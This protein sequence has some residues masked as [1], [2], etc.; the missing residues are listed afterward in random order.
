MKIG[1]I[2]IL[3]FLL[4]LSLANDEFQSLGEMW[5]SA[6]DKVEDF[7]KDSSAYKKA[8]EMYSV[9]KEKIVDTKKTVESFLDKKGDQVKRVYN[10]TKGKI[11]KNINQPI[12]KTI[13]DA[14]KKLDQNHNLQ[15]SLRT[16]KK[17]GLAQTKKFTEKSLKGDLNKFKDTAENLDTPKYFGKDYTGFSKENYKNAWNYLKNKGI[18]FSDRVK[19]MKKRSISQNLG[20]TYIRSELQKNQKRMLD[21]ETIIDGT[22]N[23]EGR[24]LET[25]TVV[26]FE[27]P[28]AFTL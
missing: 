15:E 6:K 9:P 17:N 25:E 8:G 2:V 10:Q 20:Y 26:P 24:R 23:D 22:V 5:E 27:D 12:D 4:S 18:S 16:L 11:E 14:S 21:S 1:K 28:K 7:V 13:W 3:A 19:A